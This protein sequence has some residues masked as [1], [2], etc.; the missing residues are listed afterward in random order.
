MVDNNPTSTKNAP[1]PNSPTEVR[2][3][4]NTRSPDA[5]TPSKPMQPSAQGKPG[6]PREEVDE[7][8]PEGM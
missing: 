8:E 4:D 1:K 5:P 7:P 2:E 6:S 3:P